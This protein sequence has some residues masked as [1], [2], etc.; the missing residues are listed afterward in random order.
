MTRQIMRQHFRN[1]LKTVYFADN[2]RWTLCKGAADGQTE[3]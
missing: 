2:H 1:Y 3:T